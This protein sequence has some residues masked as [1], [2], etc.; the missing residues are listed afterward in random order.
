[1]IHMARRREAPRQ[2]SPPDVASGGAVGP[3]PTPFL[4]QPFRRMQ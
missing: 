1:M 4:P 2:G 3:L